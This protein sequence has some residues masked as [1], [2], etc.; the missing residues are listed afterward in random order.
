M[1]TALAVSNDARATVAYVGA[2]LVLLI[3]TLTGGDLAHASGKLGLTS[4]LHGI[5]TARLDMGW[6]GLIAAGE[7]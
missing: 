1:P 4:V 7:V 5:R 3:L 6:P 2:E